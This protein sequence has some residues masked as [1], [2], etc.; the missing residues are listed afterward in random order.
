M[1]LLSDYSKITLQ[2]KGGEEY[3]KDFDY[4]GKFAPHIEQDKDGFQIYDLLTDEQKAIVDQVMAKLAKIQA[5]T[6]EKV[7]PEFDLNNLK[8][9][10]S[11]DFLSTNEQGLT[12]NSL[13]RRPQVEGK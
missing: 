12:M 1:T 5:E 11:V 13:L 6:P 10:E 8:K 3:M 7:L 4:I 9:V 2:G